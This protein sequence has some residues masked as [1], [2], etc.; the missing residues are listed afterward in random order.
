MQAQ[1][2]WLQHD[3][4]HLSVF[5]SSTWDHLAHKFVIGQLKVPDPTEITLYH[6]EIHSLITL[7]GRITLYHI[8]KEL[9]WI[10]IW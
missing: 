5:K 2:G 10:L 1:A 9:Y 4:G 3:L 6:V 8:L 7:L